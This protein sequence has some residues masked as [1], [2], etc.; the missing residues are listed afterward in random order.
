VEVCRPGPPR[1]NTATPQRTRGRSFHEFRP[2]PGQGPRARRG[3]PPRGRTVSP[4][5]TVD[6]DTA[7]TTCP[8]RTPLLPVADRRPPLREAARLRA[9]ANTTEADIGCPVQCGVPTA[10]QEAAVHPTEPRTGRTF[11]WLDHARRPACGRSAGRALRASSGNPEQRRKLCGTVAGVA[12]VLFFLTLLR[13]G[14]DGPG[15]P[16]AGL[17]AESSN[18][19]SS[20]APLAAAGGLVAR[21]AYRAALWRVG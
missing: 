8:P 5:A 11:P 1:V 9:H 21:A 7:H 2:L 3:I 19:L 13:A 14:I 10:W 17:S 15:A 6:G 20:W 18:P 12:T 4:S 16:A